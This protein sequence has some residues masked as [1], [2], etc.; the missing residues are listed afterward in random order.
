MTSLSLQD[1]AEVLAVLGLNKFVL[2]RLCPRLGRAGPQRLHVCRTWPSWASM[3]LILRTSPRTPRMLGYTATRLHQGRCEGSIPTSDVLS[4]SS[5][6]WASASSLL[7][8]ATSQ[9]HRASS[10][11]PQSSFEGCVGKSHISSRSAYIVG[12]KTFMKCV[13]LLLRLLDYECARATVLQC[14]NMT[15]LQCYSFT[16]L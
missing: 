14:Y 13:K 1:F 5:L 15:L 12:N 10:G 16:V 11:K 3:S 7:I 4:M 9:N 2:A 6:E 8:R